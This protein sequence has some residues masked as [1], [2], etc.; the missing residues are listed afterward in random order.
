MYVR[1]PLPSTKGSATHACACAA[2]VESSQGCP[3][4]ASSLALRLTTMSLEFKK[5]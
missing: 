2:S 1:M 5:W 3:L 4:A